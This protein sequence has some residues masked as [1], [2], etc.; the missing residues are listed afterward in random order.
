MGVYFKEQP[1]SRNDMV[2]DL[3]KKYRRLPYAL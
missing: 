2:Y 3:K 1:S